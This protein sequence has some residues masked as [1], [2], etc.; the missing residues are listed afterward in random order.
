MEK[1]L[2]F[3]DGE[4]LDTVYLKEA[5]DKYKE[6]LTLL[7]CNL[8]TAIDCRVK[9]EN[10]KEDHYKGNYRVVLATDQAEEYEEIIGVMINKLND[11]RNVINDLNVRI[12]FQNILQNTK[13]ATMQD[14]KHM[15]IFYGE[16]PREKKE[17]NPDKYIQ[18]YAEGA[19][20]IADKQDEKKEFVYVC[21]RKD[22]G[23]HLYHFLRNMRPTGVKVTPCNGFQTV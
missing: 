9:S 15:E 23:S 11:K 10:C 13:I 21:A 18:L 5:C 2:L 14:M 19:K 8:F 17:E 22:E 1:E 20:E 12:N 3:P 16:H 6:K 7:S 4:T